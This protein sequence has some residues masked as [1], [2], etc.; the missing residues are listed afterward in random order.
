MISLLSIYVFE[1]CGGALTSE[2]GSFASPG[3]PGNYPLEVEC[4]WTIVTSPG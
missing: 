2:H 1:A 3:F 4:V